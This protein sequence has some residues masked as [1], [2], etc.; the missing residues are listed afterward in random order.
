VNTPQDDMLEHDP[1]ISALYRKTG[2]IEPPAS[3]DE[4]VLANA[5]R[6]V[7]QRRN[8]WM[9]PLSTAAVLM[10]GLTVLLKLNSEWQPTP[11]LE[12]SAPTSAANEDKLAEAPIR[13]MAKKAAPAPAETRAL[14]SAPPSIATAPR[15]EQ[16]RKTAREKTE[17]AKMLGS[18][19]DT[20]PISDSAIQQAEKS[21]D[22]ESPVITGMA[23]AE[24]KVLEP[25]EWIK[26]IR[27]L[28]EAKKQ[29]EA[30]KELKAFRKRYPDY[31]LPDDLKALIP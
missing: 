8:R 29:D 9:L 23:Q 19:S 30:E 15:D 26:K 18:A 10:L 25:K 13:M 1:H 11:K 27:K 6:A 4:T 24:Q 3:L 2:N 14:K 16:P 12:D 7:R 22:T 21:K 5:R 28:L 17:I 20:A 31:K